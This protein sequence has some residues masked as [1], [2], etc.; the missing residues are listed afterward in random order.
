M[1]I[2]LFQYHLPKSRIAHEPVKPRDSSRLLVMDREKKRFAHRH[3]SDLPKLLSKGDILVLN[4]TK[5]FPARLI[6]KKKD[7]GGRVEVFLLKEAG[8]SRCLAPARV[9]NECVW[10]ILIGHK[11]ARVGMEVV[12]GTSVLQYASTSRSTRMVGEIIRRKDKSVWLMKFNVPRKDFMRQ[13]ETIG[14]TPLPP[15]IKV[16]KKSKSNKKKLEKEY[17]TVY[18]KKIG[19]AAAPT[20]GL[21]F[22][23]ELLDILNKKGVQIEY[24]TLHVSY[25]TFQPVKVNNIERHNMHSEWASIDK[26]TAGRL[27]KA[28][29]EGR[30]IIAVGTTSVRT[31]ESFADGSGVL[32]FARAEGDWIRMF[33]YPGYKFRF[34]DA[35]ITNFHLPRSTLLML[36]AAFAGRRR[37]LKAYDTAI[38]KGYR[39]YSFGDAMMIL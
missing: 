22:T 11:N 35:M 33:I 20:A 15:Y 14:D 5:V 18:A 2:K 36:V 13:I 28:K 8:S 19:S 39:F 31:L 6:G 9:E 17:Q 23:S 27:N 21:H 25:G 12:L 26:T 37:V 24:I 7:T 34:I 4:D 10:E 30:R 32:Q 1:D 29:K 3:F 38:K 16:K